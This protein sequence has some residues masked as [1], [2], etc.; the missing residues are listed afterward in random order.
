MFASVII[1]RDCIYMYTFAFHLSLSVAPE[2]DPAA[3]SEAILLEQSVCDWSS[4]DLAET[5]IS[6]F[7]GA[8][9]RS[10]IFILFSQDIRYQSR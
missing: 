10:L 3:Y 6:S 1:S 8:T 4:I 2:K 5:T 7:I 9:P